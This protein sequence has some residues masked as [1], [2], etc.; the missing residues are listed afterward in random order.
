MLVVIDVT[1]VSLHLRNGIA[2]LNLFSI[3]SF[4]PLVFSF[5]TFV[6]ISA[7][8]IHCV[9]LSGKKELNLRPC[10][11]KARALPLSYFPFAVPNGFEPLTLAL[12]VGRSSA[13]LQYRLR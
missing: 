7:A 8:Q 12:T 1:N 4:N 2:Q 13:E 11:Y 5:N 9:V 10:A 3:I 6:S